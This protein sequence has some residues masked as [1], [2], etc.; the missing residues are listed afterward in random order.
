MEVNINNGRQQKKPTA[1]QM[2][3]RLKSAVIHLDKTKD[4]QSIYFD[5]KGMRLTVDNNEGY[6]IV[7]TGCHRHIFDMITPSGVS[8][9]FLYVKRFVE[10]ALANDCTVKDKKG[11]VTR[12]YNKL[13][14]VLKAKSDKS[15]YNIAWYCDVWFF[16]IFAPLYDIGESEAESI[17][18]FER[19]CHSLARNTVIFSEKK[20]DVTV[21]EYLDKLIE[22]EKSLLDGMQDQILFKKKSDEE[23]AQE[24]V[25]ALTEKDAEEAVEGSADGE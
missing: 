10:I 14:D 18:T 6:A 15:E 4:T 12:S 9:P 16:N 1:A 19:Y 24:E 25:S 5:D 21:K 13:L 17:L 23:L 8:R 7:G 3:Q 22:A 11:N 20:S 2:A